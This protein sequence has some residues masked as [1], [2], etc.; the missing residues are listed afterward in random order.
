M[1][2]VYRKE[3]GVLVRIDK[4]DPS[5]LYSMTLD[6]KGRQCYVELSDQE[7]AK[8]AEDAVKHQE[9]TANSE[10]VGTLTDRIEFLMNRLNLTE[11]DFIAYLRNRPK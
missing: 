3:R 6:A 1:E 8:R 11:A 5:K 4:R 2:I 7:Q 10:F 9:N